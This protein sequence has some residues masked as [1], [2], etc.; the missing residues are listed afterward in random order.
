MHQPIRLAVLL[1]G[2]GTTLQNLLDRIAD[3]TLPAEVGV[4]VSSKA[5][6][7]GLTRAGRA[8]VRAEV[9]ERRGCASRAEFSRRVFDHCRAADAD[10]VCLAG[11]LQLLE[12]PDDF[13]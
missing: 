13:R 12:V 7:F 8:G 6:A 4:V 3:D 5:D 11:F 9:V 1:S 2:G 10:L